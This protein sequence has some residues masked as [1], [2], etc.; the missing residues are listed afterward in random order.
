MQPLTRKELELHLVRL[1]EKYPDR[2]GLPN[3]RANADCSNHCI[4]GQIDHDTIGCVAPHYGHIYAKAD[5]A[6][7]LAT[8]AADLNNAGMPWGEIPKLLGI[9]PGEVPIGCGGP[10]LGG[11]D[12]PIA[13]ANAEADAAPELAE[14]AHVA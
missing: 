1:A 6:W 3:I 11:P 12:R 5:G 4:L 7:N 9:V 2:I 14:A 10:S 8:K 13:S